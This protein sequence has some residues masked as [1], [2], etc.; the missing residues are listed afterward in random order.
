MPRYGELYAA[1]HERVATLVEAVG[2]DQAA[3][4]T[5]PACPEW[6]IKDV[7]AHLAGV[8]ADVL[9]GNIEG[10]ATDAWTAAQVEKRREL[11]ATQVLAEWRA[12]APGFAALLDDFPGWYGAQLVADVTTH[13]QDLRAALGEPPMMN[14]GVTCTLEFLVSAVAHPA[15]AARGIGP[16][17]IRSGGM[18]W[19]VGGSA[20]PTGDPLTAVASA[21]DSG[22]PLPPVSAPSVAVLDAD[23]RELCRAF[24]GRRSAEQIR[25]FGWSGDP[26]AYLPLFAQPPFFA[27]RHEDLVD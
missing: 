5:V 17:E 26:D 12:A 2:D 23:P 6:T 8:C 1:A 14:D 4:T 19:R 20:G 21:I 25:R 13:E 11:S 16:L 7:I 27:L 15:A 9:A 24:T 18:N 10:A 3:T 22:A